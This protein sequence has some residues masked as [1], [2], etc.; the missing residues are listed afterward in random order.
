MMKRTLVLAGDD[1]LE[2]AEMGGNG[3]LR[4]SDDLVRHL[5]HLRRAEILGTASGSNRSRWVCRGCGWHRENHREVN[6]HARECPFAVDRLGPFQQPAAA[7][8][9]AEPS[10][11]SQTSAAH[12]ELSDPASQRQDDEM[13]NVL[14]DTLRHEHDAA[15][16]AHPP[17]PVPQPL[18]RRA[19]ITRDRILTGES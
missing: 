19:W 11:S 4:V 10:E 18:V 15:P 17:Q 16:Q 9:A 2:H 7:D 3:V 8:A 6:A 13:W 1:R 12:P 14:D 5:R